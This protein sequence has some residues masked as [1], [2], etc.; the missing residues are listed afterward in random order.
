MAGEKPGTAKA[1]VH[2]SVAT[3]AFFLFYL[4][5][6]AIYHGITAEQLHLQM[7]P[8]DRQDFICNSL[9]LRRAGDEGRG[10]ITG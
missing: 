4:L 8:T 7:I 10:N 3:V 5:R 9:F 6:G 1:V 2:L